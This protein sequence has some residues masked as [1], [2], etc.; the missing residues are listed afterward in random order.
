M[1]TVNPKLAAEWHPNKNGDLKPSDIRP[2][3]GKKVWWRCERGHEWQ[4]TVDSRSSGRGC[5]FCNPQTS[6]AEQA[7]LF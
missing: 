7:I 2:H 3:Y 4:A 1:A 5:P 6:F